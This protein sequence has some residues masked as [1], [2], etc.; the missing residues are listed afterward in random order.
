MATYLELITAAQDES[1]KR[2][3]QAA[4]GV[5]AGEIAEGD[6]GVAPYKQDPEAHANRVT[7]AA[8]ALGPDNL[9]N[10]ADA[11]LLVLIG[12]NEGATLAQITGATD[13]QILVA[14]QRAADLFAGN[15]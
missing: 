2:K 4:I 13:A 12:I 6:D 7:W 9:E 1:L 14:A 11:M 15:P 5:V 3:V 10:V 8:G